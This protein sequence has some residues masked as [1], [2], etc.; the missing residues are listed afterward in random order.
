MKLLG[1]L[2]RGLLFVISAPS[3]TGKTT[4]VRMLTAEFSSIRE[5]ISFTTRKMRPNEVSGFDYHFISEADFKKKII[6]E[7]FLEYAQI[8]NHYSGTSKESVETELNKGKHLI[9]VIDT[10]GAMQLKKK[11]QPHIFLLAL[12]ILTS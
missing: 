4:L 10:Q 5:S 9:L 8:F 7:E 11:L 12:R 6:A 1:N 3:G 2:P